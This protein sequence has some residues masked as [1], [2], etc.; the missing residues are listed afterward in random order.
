METVVVDR[1]GALW[2]LYLNTGSCRVFFP[3]WYGIQAVHIRGMQSVCPGP[4]A[5]LFVM[6]RKP[7][8]LPTLCPTVA[9]EEGQQGDVVSEALCG[10]TDGPGS[11]SP[12]P[13]SVPAEQHTALSPVIQMLYV[14]IQYFKLNTEP[15][16]T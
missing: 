8:S 10:E 13:G 11:A 1:L 14:H 2:G 15:R 16:S 6:L 5:C 12:Q 4:D 9:L 3:F 7:R